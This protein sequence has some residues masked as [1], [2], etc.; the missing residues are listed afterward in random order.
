[1]SCGCSTCEQALREGSS[2]AGPWNRPGLP[3]LALRLGTHSRFLARMVAGLSTHRFEDGRRPLQGL[4]TRDASDPAIALLDAWATVADVLCFYTERI[5]NE[6]YLRTAAE[7]RSL[8]ELARLAGYVPRPGL[9]ATAY[10]AYTLEQGHAVD[11]APGAKVQ[12]VPGPGELPQT[13]ET[14]EA[15]SARWDWSQLKPR[16]MGPQKIPDVPA[17][18]AL[19]SLVLK[20]TGLQLKP[21]DLLLFVFGTSSGEQ[22]GRFIATV[23][24]DP[25]AQ[26]TTVTLLASPQVPAATAATAM[27]SRA[28]AL[29]SI[30]SQKGE[31]LA[32]L[33]DAL[34]KAP[35]TPPASPARLP[36]QL[37]DYLSPHQETTYRM[38]TVFRPMLSGLLFPALQAR[39]LAPEPVQVYVLRKRAQLFGNAAPANVVTISGGTATSS[40]P[41][42]NE[43]PQ[44]LDLDGHFDQMPAQG[45][46]V[47]D[48]GDP[49]PA[50]AILYRARMASSTPLPRQQIFYTADAA[51]RQSR[52]DYGLSGPTTRVTL[53]TPDAWYSGTLDF[54]ALRRTSVYAQSE[55]LPLADVPLDS[56]VGSDPQDPASTGGWQIEL[57]GLVDGLQSGR[58]LLVEGERVD[59]PDVTGVRGGELVML[60]GTDHLPPQYPGDGDHTRLTFARPGLSYRYKRD[61]VTLYANVAKASHGETVTDILGAGDASKALATYPLRQGPLTYLPAPTAFGAAST[62]TVRVD[63][64]AWQEVPSLADLGPRD[65]AYLLQALPGGK[66]AVRFGD[67][68]QGSRPGTGQD[69]VVATYRKGLGTGGNL[70]ASRLTLLATKPLGVKEVTNPIPS[71]GGTDPEG[72]APLR[73]HIPLPLRAMDRVV[74]VADYEAFAECHAGIGK[75]SAALLPV[76]TRPVVHLTLTGEGDLPL[77]LTS[78]VVANLRA[79]LAELG[80]PGQGLQLALRELR[81]LALSARLKRDPAFTF[82]DVAARARQA[83]LDAFGFDRRELGQSVYLSEILGALQ[84]VPGVLWADVDALADLGEDDAF[85]GATLPST[86]PDVL[87]MAL[88]RPDPRRP[89]R[90]LPAQLALFSAALPDTLV[91]TEWT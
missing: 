69:N 52:A 10:V 58:W 48:R 78:D 11:I 9:S 76:G 4:R 12:S 7:T 24:E 25:V 17:A 21:N 6:G 2:P 90:I 37:S 43:S 81:V 54:G 61:T 15:L 13:F 85:G 59:L 20:G 77:S 42:V 46:I 60:A 19:D 47:V 87:P 83:L 29:G 75:A 72:L 14:A 30:L 53:T 38:I 32:A 82:E 84:A 62:L 66:R 70:A 57:D 65:R 41:T 68:R 80:D 45:W 22:A 51:S 71:T 63:G 40:A 39:Q 27:T 64:V 56:P 35:G 3:A 23:A 89:S 28:L 73:R 67:G 44:Q 1:M 91:L 50:G 33:A 16:Q 88:A 74:S 86:R 36:R 31:A 79:A 49:D 26:I 8:E 18:Q 34:G 5:G 55:R